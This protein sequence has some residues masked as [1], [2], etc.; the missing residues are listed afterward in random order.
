MCKIVSCILKIEKKT[1]QFI[2]PSAV[3]RDKCVVQVLFVL[4]VELV[5]LTNAN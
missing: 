5:F 1:R 2:W 3:G 4:V